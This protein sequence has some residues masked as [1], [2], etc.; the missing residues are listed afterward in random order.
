M[1]EIFELKELIHVKSW[2]KLYPSYGILNKMR[3]NCWARRIDK[4]MYD[5]IYL[6]KSRPKIHIMRK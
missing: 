2:K 4:N 1:Q 6:E 5:V 3:W